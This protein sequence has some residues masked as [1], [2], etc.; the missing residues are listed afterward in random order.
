VTSA[1]RDAEVFTAPEQFD[2][3]RSEREFLSF[4]QGLHF[5]LGSHLARREMEVSLRVFA[6]RLPDLELTDPQQVGIAGTVLRGPK[7]LPV[8]FEAG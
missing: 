8:R 6:E 3:W 2:P 7:A 4:G 1:N 5:C